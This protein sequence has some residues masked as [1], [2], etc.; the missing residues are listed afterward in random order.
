LLSP[1]GKTL[2]VSGLQSLDVHLDNAS[3]HLT[4]Q[5]FAFF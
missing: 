2:P 5:A 3:L 4:E 1:A